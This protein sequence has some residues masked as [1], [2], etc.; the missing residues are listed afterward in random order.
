M[1]SLASFCLEDNDEANLGGA[2]GLRK[3]AIIKKAIRPIATSN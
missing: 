1:S 2:G 3:T